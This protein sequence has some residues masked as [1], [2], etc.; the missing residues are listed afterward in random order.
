MR[1]AAFFRL[2]HA[3]RT[4]VPPYMTK[5][6][7]TSD[8]NL[9]SHKLPVFKRSFQFLAV[10][11]NQSA[12]PVFLTVFKFPDVPAAVGIGQGALAGSLAILK[13]TDIFAAVGISHG[14]LAVAL[15][16]LELAD[17]FSAVGI[18]QCPLPVSF[19]KHPLAHVGSAIGLGIG[20]LSDLAVLPDTDDFSAAGHQQNA[21]SVPETIFETSR[22]RV[23]GGINHGSL[24]VQTIP[25]CTFIRSSSRRNQ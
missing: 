11:I 23:T 14:P 20:A 9:V 16:A 6:G 17:I 19:A 24:A 8:F 7:P 13:F 18:G 25:G 21:L 15:I 2:P 12:L 5:A 4:I 22:V 3:C 1:F 10:R